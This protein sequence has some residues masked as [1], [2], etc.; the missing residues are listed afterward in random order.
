MGRFELSSDF[1][2]NDTLK[3]HVNNNFRVVSSPGQPLHHDCARGQPIYPKILTTG[4]G[5]AVHLPSIFS[6]LIALTGKTRPN[7]VYIGTPFFDREDKYETG[8]ASF[9]RIGCNIK[10]LMVAKECTTPS[11]EEM[12]RIVVHWADLIMI[13]GGNSLFA[14]LRWQSIGLDRLL[15]EAATKGKV[16]CGG[17]AGCGC[18]FESMQTDSLKPEAC[19]LSERVLAELSPEERLDWSFVRITCLGFMDGFC[20]PHID[21]VGT[22]NIAR[23]DIA[24]KMLLEAHLEASSP[25]GNPSET[26]GRRPIFG[27][28]VDEQA[29]IIY[30]EGKNSVHSAGPRFTNFLF[31]NDMNNEVVSIPLVPNTEEAATLDELVERAIRSVAALQSPLDLVVST[32]VSD[33]CHRRG[34]SRVGSFVNFDDLSKLME[35]SSLEHSNAPKISSSEIN[36][37]RL[38]HQRFPSHA[39][40]LP[41]MGENNLQSTHVTYT[42][43]PSFDS[44]LDALPLVVHHDANATALYGIR[45]NGADT[46]GSCAEQS[47]TKMSSEVGRRPVQAST[48]Q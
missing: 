30:E 19:K 27:L 18:Y 7:V 3:P 46:T 5:N 8:T 25:S 31:V 43:T 33:A 22:N 35:H 9:R 34:C 20:I 2:I 44:F 10:R 28:G 26:F 38:R 45:S 37:I 24:K 23:M 29:A 42:R 13:S 47:Q 15:H 39:V 32:E 40:P 1:V 14:M 41:R 21:T 11:Q 6:K 16:L 48:I 12:T 36:S 17:L 4:S